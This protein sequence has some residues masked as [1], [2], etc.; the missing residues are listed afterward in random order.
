MKNESLSKSIYKGP[1]SALQHILSLLRRPRA[2][3]FP[4]V[5]LF[6]YCKGVG[7]VSGSGIGVT[8]IMPSQAMH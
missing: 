5:A 2:N 7:G 8:C 3:G 6:I 1:K 4:N